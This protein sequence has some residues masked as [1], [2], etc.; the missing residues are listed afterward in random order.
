VIVETDAAG[1]RKPSK[2]KCLDRIGG[3][4]TAIFACGLAERD[5]GPKT[6]QG[7]GIAWVLAYTRFQPAKLAA[8]EFDAAL[9]V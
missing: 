8:V 3:I 9:I 4:V 2:A 6:Y 5:E 1:N 7:T